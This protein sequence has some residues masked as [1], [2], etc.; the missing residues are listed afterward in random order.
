MSSELNSPRPDVESSITLG[1]IISMVARRWWVILICLILGVGTAAY[2]IVKL[3]KKYKATSKLEVKTGT[4]EILGSRIQSDDLEVKE[5]V[6]TVEVKLRDPN[7]IRR[8]I[9]REDVRNLDF[10]IPPETSL[11]PNFFAPKPQTTPGKP[12]DMDEILLARMVQSWLTVAAERNT[13]LVSIAAL[14]HSPEAAALLANALAEEY[15]VVEDSR[16]SSGIG[17]AVDAVKEEAEKVSAELEAAEQ[18]LQ[19]YKAPLEMKLTLDTQRE[20]L[21]QLRERYLPK[22]PERATAESVFNQLITS[23]LDSVALVAKSAE[24]RDYWRDDP[25]LDFS[26]TP[27]ASENLEQRF[28]IAQQRVQARVSLLES[29]IENYKERYDSL[30]QRLVEIGVSNRSEDGADV[31]FISSAVVPDPRF[32]DSPDRKVILLLGTIAGLGIGGSLALLL[33][34]A[35]SRIRGAASLEAITGLPLLA[36]V[37]RSSILHPA[38]KA[39]T[40]VFEKHGNTPQADAF[41]NLRAHIQ[42][43]DLEDSP[44]KVIAITSARNGE[45][46]TTISAELAAS[47]ALRGESVLLIDFD[48]RKGGLSAILAPQDNS[49]GLINYLETGKLNP[50][51]I[52]ETTVENLSLLPIGKRSDHHSELLE[53]DKIASLVSKCSESYDRIIIDTPPILPVRDALII[54]ECVDSIIFVVGMHNTNRTLLRDALGLFRKSNLHLDGVV[55]NQVPTKIDKAYTYDS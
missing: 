15:M 7:L 34:L 5:A 10:L 1:D 16:K 26:K 54:G 39:W 45:G 37:H 17:V 38:K 55:A 49:L 36:S 23:V 51:S 18:R 20:S 14:H 11:L 13:S 30:T 44:C 22:H 29:R 28:S 24:E 41:R 33:G 3:P 43:T 2:L 6:A 8:I 4:A 12:G 21:S 52:R 19:I 25:D 47:C 32:P 35:D 46:K 42:L 9:A 31:K 40:S 50:N 27:E 48:L 53:H